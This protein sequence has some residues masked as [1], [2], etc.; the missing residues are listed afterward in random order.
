MRYR[1]KLGAGTPPAAATDHSAAAKSL[2]LV[3]LALLCG[4]TLEEIEA[5][6]DAAEDRAGQ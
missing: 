2:T 4:R 5:E 1:D 6:I 3:E